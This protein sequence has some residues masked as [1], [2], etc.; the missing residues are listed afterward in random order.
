MALKGG[1][2]MLDCWYGSCQYSSA[3][4]K[5]KGKFAFTYGKVSARL[6]I[7]KGQGIWP[8]FWMLGSD[9]GSVGWPNCGEIDIL[10]NIGKEAE[11][12]DYF[13]CSICGHTVEKVS[14]E[15]C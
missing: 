8:A 2:D 14:P 7:P 5:T 4:I 13:V 6:K 9:F 10:E 11:V 12:F 3:R 1:V 15:K